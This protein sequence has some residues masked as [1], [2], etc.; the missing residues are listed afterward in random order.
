MRE[1]VIFLLLMGVLLGACLLMALSAGIRTPLGILE[2]GVISFGVLSVAYILA[3]TIAHRFSFQKAGEAELK[4]EDDIL[5][6]AT[7]FSQAALWIY[8]NL[9][10][11]DVFLSLMRWVVPSAAII[12]YSS[13]AIAKLKNSNTWRYYS[14]FALSIVVGISLSIAIVAIIGPPLEN[15]LLIDG[16]KASMPLTVSPLSSAVIVF[17]ID[18]N[19]QIRTRYGLPVRAVFAK[20]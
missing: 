19:D 7:A 17:V 2:Y 6:Q 5:L 10:Q 8:L 20:S 16:I 12:F 1:R 4:A 14:V 15:A 11:Q 9:V 13:R 18:L 3:I